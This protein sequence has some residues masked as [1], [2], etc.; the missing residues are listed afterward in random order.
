MGE[1]AGMRNRASRLTTERLALKAL[2]DSDREALLRMAADDRIKRTY[3]LP[4]F[5]DPAQAD[6]FFRRMQALCASDAHFV[7]GIYRDGELIGFLND[8]GTD[9]GRVELGYFIDPEHWNRGYAAEALRAAID[10]LFR[11]GFD[12]VAAGYFEENPASRR[13]ME[14]CGMRATGETS[15]IAYRGASHRCLYCEIRRN[16]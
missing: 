15:V 11:L 4:D 6:A 13:V 10:E 5:A 16:P 14:K 2:E 1:Q 3:M 7:Y 12:C 9:G 8:C